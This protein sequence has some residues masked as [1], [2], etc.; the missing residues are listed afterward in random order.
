MK[1]LECASARRA[2]GPDRGDLGVPAA[3]FARGTISPSA[4][5]LHGS[6]NEGDAGVGAIH[7]AGTP[8]TAAL[9]GSVMNSC[10]NQ[11]STGQWTASDLTALNALY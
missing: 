1:L 2:R 8:T 6:G 3:C 7:I 5:P 10:F 9:D 4:S 11:G